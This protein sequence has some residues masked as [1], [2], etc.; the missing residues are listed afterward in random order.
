MSP[1]TNIPPLPP[2]A[3][4]LT[5]PPPA[6]SSALPPLP[7]GATPLSQNSAGQNS[8]GQNSSVSDTL[9]DAQR[10]IE[11]AAVDPYIGF[12]KGGLGTIAG[13]ARLASKLYNPDPQATS[14]ALDWLD[15]HS[16]PEGMEQEAG[17]MG[18]SGAELFSG[19]ELLKLAGWT[20]KGTEAL[21]GAQKLGEVLQQSPAAA[22]IMRAGIE[23]LSNVGRNAV[24][25][26]GQQFVKSGGDV[27]SSAET[28]LGAGAMTG[29]SE[30]ATGGVKSLVSRI[31]RPIAARAAENATVLNSA[32]DVAA[33]V[34]DEANESRATPDINPAR[35]LPSS[36][37]AKPSSG[38]TSRALPAVPGFVEQGEDALI[39]NQPFEFNLSGTPPVE[40]AEGDSLVP[41]RKRQIGTAVE[42]RSNP[43]TFNRRAALEPYGITMEGEG[44]PIADTATPEREPGTEGETNSRNV[45][46]V[47]RYQSLTGI[48]PDANPETV[49]IGGGGT[50]KTTDPEVAKQHISTLNEAI[51]SPEFADMD[52]EQQQQ[53]IA[54]RQ[55]AQRQM[56]AYHN[57]IMEQ[58]TGH[59]VP[60]FA[61]IDI[62]AAVQRTNS[63]PEAVDRINEAH[64][65]IYNRL[66]DITGGDFKALQNAQSTA[67]NDYV[68]AEGTQAKDTTG[69][70]LA[71][72]NQNIENMFHGLRG[73]VSPS[74]LAGANQAYKNGLMTQKVSSIVERSL[75]G[76]WRDSDRAMNGRVLLNGLKQLYDS[77]GSGTTGRAAVQ[78]VIGDDTLNNLENVAKANITEEGRAKFNHMIRRVV[79]GAAG[80]IGITGA[81]HLAHAPIGYAMG[82]GAMTYYGT[83]MLLNKMASDPKVGNF[84]LHAAQN[85]NQVLPKAMIP[86]LQSI[87]SDSHSKDQDWQQQQQGGNQ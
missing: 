55:D 40:R 4:P 15:R 16:K 44:Q 24:L 52:P 9:N 79:A 71:L 51:N 37:R 42:A 13:A 22:R 46:K 14:E 35:T 38:L 39:G 59:N 78:R 1:Q 75:E 30:L 69:R 65:E 7:P 81:G 87:V 29:V 6:G 10:S 68:N 17:S 63:F 28:A 48:K 2:G 83:E 57:S 72:A 70:A 19:D 23:A 31:Q 21:K 58:Y 43:E 85:M 12:V 82:T 47:P 62:R 74:E 56:S 27:E 84:F 50:L 45:R 80:T 76:T 34:L 67:W 25:G 18:E 86:I 11:K 8:A 54:A 64:Q 60:N 20:T 73:A 41:A 26:G 36:T 77:E 66:D 33:R 5:P 49:T 53:L 32:R 61:P 3:T